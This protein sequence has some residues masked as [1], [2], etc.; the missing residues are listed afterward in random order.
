LALRT[1]LNRLGVSRR[2]F[3]VSVL[4]ERSRRGRPAAGTGRL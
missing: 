2:P 3:D 4:A 1:A